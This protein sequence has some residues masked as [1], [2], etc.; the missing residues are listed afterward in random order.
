MFT[1]WLLA[2][3]IGLAIVLYLIIRW[4]ITPRGK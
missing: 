2:F 4:L 1:D 3:W